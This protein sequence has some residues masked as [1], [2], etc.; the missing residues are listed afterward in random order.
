MKD[1]QLDSPTTTFNPSRHKSFTEVETMA[2]QLLKREHSNIQNMQ[3]PSLKLG[4]DTIVNTAAY[5]HGSLF[6]L[7]CLQYAEEFSM[8]LKELGTR[9]FLLAFDECSQLGLHRP[10]PEPSWHAQWGMSLIA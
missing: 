5:W 3:I 7:L 4:D 2:N 6:R 1:W 9:Y 10:P 8:V